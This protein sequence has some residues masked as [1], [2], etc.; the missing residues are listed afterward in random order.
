M[1]ATASQ[2][3]DARS[4]DALWPGLDDFARYHPGARHRRRIMRAL[5]RGV[6]ARSVLDVGCGNGEGLLAL[7]DVLP[8]VRAWH[9]ADF[10]PERVAATQRRLP[11]VQVHLLDIEREA[12]AQHFE[13]VLCSEVLEHL[14][15]RRAAF[16][17]LAAMVAPGGQLLITAPAGRVFATER[18]FGH[19][20]HPSA[21]ELRAFG[22]EHGLQLRAL[23]EWGF[24]FYRALKHATNVNPRWAVREF[25][26]G[27]YG[28]GHKLLAHFLYGLCF[29]D[30]P[31]P[32][33]GCQLFARFEKAVR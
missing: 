20:A 2:P 33:M 19:V 25:A 22:A 5:L 23:R 31:I 32:G 14:R 10:A 4:Y 30:C 6:R 17:R 1:T 24:P 13:L 3:L 21:A 16:G 29:A 11:D 12:L 15:D 28:P 26:S 27:Q 18:H 7:R 8:D 9:G